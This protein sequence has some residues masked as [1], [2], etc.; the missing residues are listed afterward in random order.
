VLE[1][2]VAARARE[3][4]DPAVEAVVAALRSPEATIPIAH[5]IG[6]SEGQLLRR[7]TPVLGYGP[8]TLGRIFAFNGSA[9]SRPLAPAQGSRS[10]PPTRGMQTSRT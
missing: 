5:R 7:C 9:P 8:K 4:P 1:D 2:I 10:L 3:A 6:L